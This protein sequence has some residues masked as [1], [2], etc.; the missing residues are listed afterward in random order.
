[1][2]VYN[3]DTRTETKNLKL[4][5]KKVELAFKAIHIWVGISL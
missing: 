3:F 4:K 1:M 2:G 5:K